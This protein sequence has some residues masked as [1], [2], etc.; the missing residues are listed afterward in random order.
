VAF[1]S[2]RGEADTDIGFKKIKLQ[3]QIRASFRIK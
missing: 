3:Y 2:A 1:E